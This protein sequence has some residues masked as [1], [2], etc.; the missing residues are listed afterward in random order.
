M[1]ISIPDLMVVTLVPSMTG[2]G[3]TCALA[4]TDGRFETR[5]Q[6]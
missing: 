5:I 3:A 6:R 2:I 1:N 4:G